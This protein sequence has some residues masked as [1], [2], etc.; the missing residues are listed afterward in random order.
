MCARVHLVAVLAVALAIAVASTAA[1]DGT[2]APVMNL[3]ARSPTSAFAARIDLTWDLPVG[4][5]DVWVATGERSPRSGRWGFP[6]PRQITSLPND[7][8]EALATDGYGHAVLA[9]E[10]R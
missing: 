1:G 6:R 4:V 3:Q 8:P 2:P 10:R 5:D 7:A 9:I